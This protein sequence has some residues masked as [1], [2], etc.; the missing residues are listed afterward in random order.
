MKTPEELEKFQKEM[1]EIARDILSANIV[2]ISM[3]ALMEIQK[4]EMAK[5][6]GLES[7]SFKIASKAIRDIL[8]S[9]GVTKG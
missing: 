9:G 4:A 5:P 3:Q 1:I 8:S 2:I 6:N 7:E